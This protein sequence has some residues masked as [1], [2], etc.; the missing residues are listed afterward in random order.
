MKKFP[1]IIH[2]CFGIHFIN[3]FQCSL[4]FFVNIFVG[5][6]L[7]FAKEGGDV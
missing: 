1:Y 7:A 4:E 5:Y 3:K 2:P 6:K